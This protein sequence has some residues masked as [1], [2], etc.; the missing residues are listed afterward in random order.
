MINSFRP[1]IFISFHPSVSPWE[2]NFQAKDPLIAIGYL[3]HWIQQCG[4]KN[5]Q[6]P[7][8]QYPTVDKSLNSR[9]TMQAHSPSWS[10][11]IMDATLEKHTNTHML[12][13]VRAQRAW[14]QVKVRTNH[15]SWSHTATLSLLRHYNQ[16]SQ[17]E[18]LHLLSSLSHFHEVKMTYKLQTTSKSTSTS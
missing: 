5:Q 2:K 10:T 11:S 8:N 17:C 15:K 9:L 16:L 18:T 4:K 13:Q 6:C 14:L 12:P 1:S 3:A 7:F